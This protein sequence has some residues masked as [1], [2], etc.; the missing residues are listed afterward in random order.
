MT[1]MFNSFFQDNKQEPTKALHCWW[2]TDIGWFPSQRASDAEIIFMP[3]LYR[4]ATIFVIGSDIQCLIFQPIRRSYSIGI[5]P[6]NVII[7][8]AYQWSD[9]GLSSLTCQTLVHWSKIWENGSTNEFG[10][11]Y[12]NGFKCEVVS[13]KSDMNIIYHDRSAEYENLCL[14]KRSSLE[15]KRT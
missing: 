11:I 6:F 1:Y 9:Y 14:F 10:R 13:D 7:T 12:D 2:S 5:I 3:W 8:S 4:N 15:M